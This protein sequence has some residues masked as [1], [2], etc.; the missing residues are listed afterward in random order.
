MLLTASFYFSHCRRSVLNL[1]SVVSKVSTLIYSEDVDFTLPPPQIKYCTYFLKSCTYANLFLATVLTTQMLVNAQ[2]TTDIHTSDFFSITRWNK[3]TRSR[4]FKNSFVR[5]KKRKASL[6]I[7]R[8]AGCY[9]PDC[10]LL[11]LFIEVIHKNKL[12]QIFWSQSGWV[13]VGC[14]WFLLEWDAGQKQS[15]LCWCCYLYSN[16]LYPLMALSITWSPSKFST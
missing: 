12:I 10:F 13:I 7:L 15:S 4:K 5:G 6:Q 3:T 1:Q 16:A 11:F 2:M 8:L 14:R 9:F